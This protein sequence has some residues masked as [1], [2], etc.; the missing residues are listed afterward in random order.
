MKS[1]VCLMP[2][3]CRKC[4]QLFDLSYDLEGI[5]TERIMAEL[6]RVKLGGKMLLCWKC[7]NRKEQW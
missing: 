3:Q 1:E 4:G 2:E 5:N 6:L 7:R